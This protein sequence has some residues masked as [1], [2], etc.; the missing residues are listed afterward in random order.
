MQNKINQMCEKSVKQTI[1]LCCA[2]RL[3]KQYMFS[4]SYYV[5]F[6]LLTNMYNMSYPAVYII[7][8]I[9]IISPQACN[10]WDQEILDVVMWSRSR[11]ARQA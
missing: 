4:T 3:I 1:K 10:Y 2:F 6:R 8:I 11:V 9:I 5:A 7:I